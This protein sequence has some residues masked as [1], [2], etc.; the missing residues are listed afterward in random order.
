MQPLVFLGLPPPSFSLLYSPTADPALRTLVG[1][2]ELSSLGAVLLMTHDTYSHP[3]PPYVWPVAAN[4]LP[5]YQTIG[6]LEAKKVWPTSKVPLF[7]QSVKL[8]N[9]V[10]S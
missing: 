5:S 8:R 3:Y 6:P 10:N 4:G 2:W 7:C 9:I 1:H